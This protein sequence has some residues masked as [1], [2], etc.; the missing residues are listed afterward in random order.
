MDLVR[1]E[2]ITMTVSQHGGYHDAHAV[3]PELIVAIGI[4]WLAGGIYVDIRHFYGCSFASVYQF[5]DMFMNPVLNCKELD[6]VFLDTD[7]QLKPTAVKFAEKYSDGIMIGCVGLIDGLFCEDKSL[8]NGGAD[9]T[10]KHTFLARC[11][12][13][14]LN[15]Q[16]VCDSDRCFTLFGVVAP[17]E[18][19]TRLLSR[20]LRSASK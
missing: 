15:I 4:Q 2:P 6:I 20:E 19:V 17:G 1:G 7:E 10:P 16:A 13:H 12:A 14:G 5:S 8:I 9:E 3:E 11:M 18:Q